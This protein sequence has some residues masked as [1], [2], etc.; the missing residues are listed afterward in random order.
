SGFTALVCVP[1]IAA[2]VVPNL[3]AARMAA[4]EGSAISSLRSIS[5]AEATYQ[6]RH[7]KYG[8]LQELAMERLINPDLASGT[9]RGYKIRI[10][11]TPSSSSTL[12]GYD[13]VEVPSQYRSSGRRSFYTDES[14]VI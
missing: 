13:V 12:P 11:V 8:T 3:L 14:G 7:V 9:H 2:I 5:V 6:S 1:I 4:N 10:D